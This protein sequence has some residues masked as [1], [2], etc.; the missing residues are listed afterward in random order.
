MYDDVSNTRVCVNGCGETKAVSSFGGK[1]KY[2][3]L[4]CCKLK[5][6]QMRAEKTESLCCE[7]KGGCGQYLPLD[8]FYKSRLNLCKTCIKNK[9]MTIDEKSNLTEEAVNGLEEITMEEKLTIMSKAMVSKITDLEEKISDLEEKL[10]FTLELTY[11]VLSDEEYRQ[12]K[13]DYKKL[14]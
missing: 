8:K 1:N 14:F 12:A 3:C 9:R 6:K 4:D 2:I 11:S 10:K 5:K 7:D 13:K